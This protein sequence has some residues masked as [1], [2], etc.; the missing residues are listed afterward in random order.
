VLSGTSDVCSDG[1]FHKQVA[2]FGFPDRVEFV[3]DLEAG[4]VLGESKLADIL[5]FQAMQSSGLSGAGDGG[6]IGPA[7]QQQSAPI[8]QRLLAV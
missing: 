3:G 4:E 8:D 2:R 6:S 1:I 5:E 7:C